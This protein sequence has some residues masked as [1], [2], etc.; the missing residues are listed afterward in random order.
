M[1]LRVEFSIRF[2]LVYFFGVCG[3]RFIFVIFIVATT[4][5]ELSVAVVIFIAF[6]FISRFGLCIVHAI[7]RWFLHFIL[8][9][10]FIHHNW[11]YFNFQFVKDLGLKTSWIIPL[12]RYIFNCI[13]VQ[14]ERIQWRAG[15]AVAAITIGCYCHSFSHSCTDQTG[16][17]SNLL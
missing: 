12:S 5:Q 13:I 15:D 3:F 6:F 8:R 7:A 14:R 10:L 4:S 9:C 16:S 2:I 1:R 17:R 11:F